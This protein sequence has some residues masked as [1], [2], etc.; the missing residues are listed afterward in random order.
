[1]HD[2]ISGDTINQICSIVR[3]KGNRIKIDLVDVCKQDGIKDCGLYA[4]ANAKMGNFL[5]PSNI[6]VYKKKCGLTLFS[7]ET[8]T[9]REPELGQ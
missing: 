9:S 8:V 5:N 6:H 4:L 3:S 1:M 7:V 2:D